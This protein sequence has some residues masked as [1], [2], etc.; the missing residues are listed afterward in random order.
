L[1][2]LSGDPLNLDP[3]HLRGEALDDEFSLEIGAI[4]SKMALFTENYSEM[5]IGYT[6]EKWGIV[7]NTLPFFRQHEQAMSGMFG[8]GFMYTWSASCHYD[9][10]RAHG[11]RK[12]R[13]EG[14]RAHR[15]VQNWAT[16][17]T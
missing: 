9:L 5:M 17:G 14:R 8:V 13:R 16:T 2:N 3:S 7:R 6:Y 12:H 11:V 1:L 4:N 10:Y 15:K